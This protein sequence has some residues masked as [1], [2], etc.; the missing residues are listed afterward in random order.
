MTGRSVARVAELTMEAFTDRRPSARAFATAGNVSLR[1]VR[2]ETSL[3][4]MMR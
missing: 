2:R 4:E 3:D 1:T